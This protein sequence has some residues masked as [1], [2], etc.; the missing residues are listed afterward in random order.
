MCV[1]VCFFSHCKHPRGNATK[2]YHILREGRRLYSQEALQ[3]IAKQSRRMNTTTCKSELYI[4][5]YEMKAIASIFP[6]CF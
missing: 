4:S 6:H 2:I 5:D 1:C 3:Q